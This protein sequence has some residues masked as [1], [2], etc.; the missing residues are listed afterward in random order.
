MAD[1]DYLVGTARPAHYTV[2]LDEI[3]RSTYSAG[4][5]NVLEKV[6]HEM[7]YLFGRATKAVSICPPAYYA[8][9]LCTRQRVHM[10]ELFDDSD[11]T[12]VSSAAI[13]RITSRSVH[14]KLQDSMY[15]I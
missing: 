1:A 8:D 2:L 14:S 6:T 13:N 4:A 5:A 9:I 15:Y 10:S 7:C 12:S 3:F 11:G